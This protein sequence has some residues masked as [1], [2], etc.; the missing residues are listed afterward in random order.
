MA[1]YF[2]KCSPRN[3]HV[4]PNWRLKITLFWYQEASSDEEDTENEET[5]EEDEEEPE[6]MEENDEDVENTAEVIEERSWFHS[7]YF[8][9]L[10]ILT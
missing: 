7:P 1:A 3:T 4:Y 8:S 5:E 2:S 10:V 9:S 6:E